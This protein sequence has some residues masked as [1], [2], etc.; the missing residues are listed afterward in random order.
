MTVDEAIEKINAAPKGEAQAVAERC[1]SQ[2]S[3]VEAEFAGG[4]LEEMAILID[5]AA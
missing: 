1:I 4:D 5:E 2:L 3:E